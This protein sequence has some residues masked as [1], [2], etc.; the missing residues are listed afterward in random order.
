MAACVSHQALG[1]PPRTHTCLGE[2]QEAWEAH[3]QHWKGAVC[4]PS[5]KPFL[6]KALRIGE[7]GPRNL[8]ALPG[9][10]RLLGVG[11]GLLI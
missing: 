4:L 11:Q 3:S 7:V 2:C 6:R 10:Q 5:S 8:W 9:L 1:P